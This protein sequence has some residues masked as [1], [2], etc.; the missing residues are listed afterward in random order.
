MQD[1]RTSALIN[2]AKRCL[3]E[4]DRSQAKKVAQQLIAKKPECVEGWL[5]LAGITDPRA[6]LFYLK[7]ARQINPDD[8]RVKAAIAWAEHALGED[9]ELELTVWSSENQ[10]GGSEGSLPAGHSKKTEKPEQSKLGSIFKRISRNAVFR[11]FTHLAKKALLIALTIFLGVFITVNIMNRDVVVGWATAPAQLD[12]AVKMQIERTLN[13]FL[14]QDPKIMNL[15]LEEREPLVESMRVSLIEES[16]LNLP[17]FQKHL[18]WTWNALKLNWG[19]LQL[20]SHTPVRPLMGRSETFNLN[21][22]LVLGY[23]PNTVLLAASAFLIVFLLGLPLAL[24]LSRNYG[25]WFD[26]LV[27]FFAPLS[28]I[29]SWIIGIILIALFAFELQILP[30]GRM[31]DAIPPDTFW[32]YIP[33]VLKHMILPVM[34]IVLSIFFQLVY[35]WRT[36]FITFSSEDYVELG[37]AKGL[38]HR[39]L[40]RNYILRPS[41]SY[42]ITSFS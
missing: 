22:E 40:E 4:G 2:Y 20:G 26:R 17:K 19:R 27:S 29:P 15:P 7:K 25:K 32:G 5:I 6:S 8:P 12:N 10:P 42:V 13:Q 41:L 3:R 1:K 39:S 38:S 23:L 30:A 28:S 21:R 14:R 16:G 37:K 33:V 18:R 24:F 36:F 9:S 34:S 31:Y 35:S 11:G